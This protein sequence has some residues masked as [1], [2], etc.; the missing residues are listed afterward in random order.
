MLNNRYISYLEALNNPFQKL[1]RLEFL[2]PDE[3]VAFVLDNKEPVPGYNSTHD[4]RA[5]IQSGSLSV[6]LQNGT[7]RKATIQLSNE[8]GSYDYAV[9]KLWFG[10]KI[11]LSMGLVLPD[12][13]EF[14]LPQGVFYI[15]DPQNV[16]NPT[17]RVVT[18]PLVDKWSYLNGDLL[19]N[20]ERS[21]EIPADTNI[22][23]AA[24][25]I[26]HQNKYEW[27]ETQD[28]IKMIDS[29]MPVFTDYYNGKTYTVPTD[30]QG[31]TRTVSMTDTGYTIT[32]AKTGGTF[33]KVLLELNSQFTGW[34][35]YDQTG[36]LRID[37]SQ[38][39]IS[40]ADKPILWTFSPD[41]ITL[42]GITE[43]S[44]N[45]DV[46]N[47]VRIVGEGL[48]GFEISG[49]AQNYDPRS[50][51]N[52]NLIGRRTYTEE[53]AEYWN[54]QQCQ[55]MAEYL[56]KKKTVLQK[57]ISISCQQMFHLYENGVVAIRRTDKVGSPVER[58]L[59]QSFSIPIGETGAMTINAT[60]VNDYPDIT[61]S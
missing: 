7:R 58:H 15:K 8:D 33:A 35:G 54:D 4:S 18:L 51:T 24:L 49:R 61:V 13:T 29:K 44:K 27:G 12:G 41:L 55:D 23:D 36:A 11:R 14:Y 53:K 9:N 42:L 10:Q 20:L 19:G 50:D 6:S 34:I 56:L 17:Q 3:S 31:G 5:F 48:D 22:F 32:T 21:Y 43:T 45:S 60:S 30:D 39:D 28:P 59:I 25:T 26:L 38:N 40:D 57:T 46:Y 47:D 16:Y 2:Q 1:S 52:I 37:A